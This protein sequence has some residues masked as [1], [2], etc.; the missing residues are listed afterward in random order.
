MEIETAGAGCSASRQLSADPA[1]AMKVLEIETDGASGSGK[2]MEMGKE[3]EM[4]SA[5][6]M[7][8]EM[9]ASDALGW[10]ETE[11]EASEALGWMETEMEASEVFATST[12]NRNVC[13]PKRPSRRTWICTL[14]LRRPCLS[15]RMF[16]SPHALATVAWTSRCAEAEKVHAETRAETDEDH[17]HDMR[18]AVSDHLLTF[19]R[20]RRQC[21]ASRSIQERLAQSNV[22]GGSITEGSDP[23]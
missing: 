2:A 8:T 13:N 15:H 10:M 22:S 14:R 19:G 11:M 9:E 4:G 3:T 18:N 5:C 7:E 21:D 1:A 12:T 20:P 23:R 6:W 16:P 17:D